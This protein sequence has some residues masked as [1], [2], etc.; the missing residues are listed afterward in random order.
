MCENFEPYDGFVSFPQGWGR[1]SILVYLLARPHVRQWQIL[2]QTDR[3]RMFIR[4]NSPADVEPASVINPQVKTWLRSNC[5]E[6]TALVDDDLD[7]G[8]D[9]PIGPL[10][11]NPVPGWE[12]VKLA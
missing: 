6:C 10:T 5:Q 2:D 1:Q 3:G 4:A 8:I 9:R 11:M 12:E 7:Q